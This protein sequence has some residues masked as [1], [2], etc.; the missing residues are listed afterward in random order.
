MPPAPGDATPLA[1]HPPLH[2]AA[3]RRRTSPHRLHAQRPRRCPRYYSPSLFHKQPLTNTVPHDDPALVFALPCETTHATLGDLAANLD[4]APPDDVW[5]LQPQNDSLR[6]VL[7]SELHPALT[8]RLLD[9][10]TA[11]FGAPPDAV[12]LWIGDGRSTTSMHKDPYENLYHVL[13]GAKSFV[14]VPPCDVHRL[15]MKELPVWRWRKDD[16]SGRC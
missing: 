16:S 11:V 3:P 10:G 12:N 4:A 1:P 9:F 6:T 8:T 14:L 5:Y 13:H 15:G 2:L 7:P